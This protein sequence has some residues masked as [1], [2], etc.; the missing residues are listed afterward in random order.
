METPAV[1]WAC[2]GGQEPSGDWAFKSTSA[3][4]GTAANSSYRPYMLNIKIYGTGSMKLN[5]GKLYAYVYA[6][7]GDVHHHGGQS[8]GG[9]ISSLLCFRQT[10]Q[11]HYDESSSTGGS[12]MSATIISV[13]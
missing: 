2:T 7:L 11:G 8:F 5:T 10:G 3:M 12:G 6:P 4:D 1:S 13:K 9:V